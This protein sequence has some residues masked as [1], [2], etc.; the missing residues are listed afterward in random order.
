MLLEGF[1][2]ALPTSHSNRRSRK[3]N[4][5]LRA[6]A[7]VSDSKPAEPAVLKARG[8]AA[9]LA[10]LSRCGWHGQAQEESPYILRG[11]GGALQA[12]PQVLV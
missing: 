2:A 5:R 11:G 3:E 6:P 10:A 12:P 7:R 9:T 4:G 1:E 8:W